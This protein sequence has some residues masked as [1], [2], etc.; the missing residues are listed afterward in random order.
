MSCKGILDTVFWTR[1]GDQSKWYFR[2]VNLVMAQKIGGNRARD[3][4]LS[5]R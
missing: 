5:E 4:E 3:W 2:K 1:M